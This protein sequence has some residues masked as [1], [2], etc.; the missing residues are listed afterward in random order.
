MATRT[1]DKIIRFF[2]G[3]QEA[4]LCEI[5]VEQA[6]DEND[7]LNTLGNW[8][9]LKEKLEDGGIEKLLEVGIGAGEDDSE[10]FRK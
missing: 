10:W 8:D 1:L 3:G 4:I 9:S 5:V 2:E 6:A 7:D